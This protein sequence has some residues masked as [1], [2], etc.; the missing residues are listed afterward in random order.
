MARLWILTENFSTTIEEG[1]F[2]AIRFCTPTKKE[3][4]FFCH[5]HWLQI[6][7]PYTYI[8]AKSEYRSSVGIMANDRLLVYG[9]VTLS[10]YHIGNEICITV[11]RERIESRTSLNY[12]MVACI[13]G[14]IKIN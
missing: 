5:P 10:F 3:S 12:K 7:Y 13:S 1:E 11:D 6:S 14:I 9:L 8:F 4:I 2:L